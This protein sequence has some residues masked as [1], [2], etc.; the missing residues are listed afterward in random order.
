M[1]R[2]NYVEEDTWRKSKRERND[3]EESRQRIKIK[4]G[5]LKATKNIRNG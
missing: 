5:R 1:K 2:E 4:R 3:Q